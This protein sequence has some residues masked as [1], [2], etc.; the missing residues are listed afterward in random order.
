MVIRDRIYRFVLDASKHKE[1]TPRLSLTWKPPMGVAQ[2]IPE[3][4][5]SPTWAPQVLTI[6]TLFPPDDASV[7]YERGTSISREWFE[8]LVASAI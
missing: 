6:S 7:G 2:P 8:A 3:R 5:L 4:Y 1:P